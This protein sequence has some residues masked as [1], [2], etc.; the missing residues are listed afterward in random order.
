LDCDGEGEEKSCDGDDRGDDGMG[1][2][3]NG[4]LKQI[5][6]RPHDDDADQ[7]KSFH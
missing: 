1:T 2:A 4:E 7:T 3:L 5:F 6:V